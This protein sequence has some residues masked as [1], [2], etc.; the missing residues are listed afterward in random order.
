M[1]RR[2]EVLDPER[3]EQAIAERIDALSEEKLGRMST[4]AREQAACH[5]SP[6]LVRS[7]LERHWNAHRRTI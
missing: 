7:N 3:I 1:D 2:D 5:L 4:Y 6:A